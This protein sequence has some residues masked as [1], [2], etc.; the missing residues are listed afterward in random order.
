MMGGDKID[1]GVQSFYNSGTTQ[2]PNTSLPDV[3]TALATGV[4]NLSSGSHGTIEDLN[5]TSTSP[6]FGA[7]TSFLNNNEGAITGKP[8]AY[9][10][11]MLLDEQLHVVSSYP[12]TGAIPVGM[13]S[14]WQG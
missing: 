5:N 1:L 8:K 2:T 7:L 10:N 4:V 9:L 13:D 6:L 11:W 14:P 12:Q 3:L